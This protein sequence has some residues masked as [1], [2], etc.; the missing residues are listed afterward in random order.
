MMLRCTAKVLA[1]LGPA[2]ATLT[3][4]L[5]SDEDWYLNLLWIERRKCL[6]LTHAGTLFSVFVPD[7]RAA[8]LRPVGPYITRAAAAALRGEALPADCLGP[9]DTNTVQLGRT[10][11]RQV[12]GF[13]NDLARQAKAGVVAGGGLRNRDIAEL[14][15]RLR[16][17]LHNRGGYNSAIMLVAQRLRERA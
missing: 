17:T 9:L 13:M 11:D 6:L 7:V 4:Q 1:L 2:S 3:G 14:N 16:R 5:P 12:L 10:A 15:R 8:D